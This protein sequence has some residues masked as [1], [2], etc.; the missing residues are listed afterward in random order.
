L[1]QPDVQASVSLFAA[2]K[3]QAASRHDALLRPRLLEVLKSALARGR[4]TLLSAPAGAGKTSLLAELPQAF[5]ETRWAWL[6]LD[7]E[8]NDPSRFAA[9]MAASI[10]RVYT[11]LARGALAPGQSGTVPGRQA[12]TAIINNVLRLS[13]DPIGLVLDDF[14]VLG[15]EAIH[16]TVEYLIDRLPPNMRVIIGARQDPPMALP[17]WRARGELA[18]IR[19]SDLSFTGQETSE[20]MNSCLNGPLDAEGVRMIY[21]RTGGWAAGL[22]L[23]ATSLTQAPA[24]SRAWLEQGMQGRQRVFEFLSEEVFDRQAPDLQRFLLET[25]ILS[26]LHPTTCDAL[27]GRSDSQAVLESL[28]R[29]NLYVAAVDSAGTNYR[30]HD[31]FA[32]FLRDRLWRERSGDWRSLH[33]RAAVLEPEPGRR[34]RHWMSA[35]NWDEAAEAIEHIGPEYVRRGFS[36]SL[37]RWILGI[38]ETVRLARPRLSLL[39][40]TSLGPRRSPAPA[41]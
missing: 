21:S 26:P 13:S 9:A 17:R 39:L 36:V 27:A 5:P 16:Q 8:D 31:L 18:E 2:T 11:R 22:R 10:E 24:S 35:E 28:Y 30:Y 1:T 14:H 40:G 6:L 41:S 20:L 15:D 34:I 4:V 29:Q 12:A 37:R 19:M 3:L 38:P 7:E 32:D 23:L 33:E 25:S